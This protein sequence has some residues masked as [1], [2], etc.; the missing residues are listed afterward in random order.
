MTTDNLVGKIGTYYRFG[1]P[2]LGEIH[3]AFRDRKS[4]YG[5]LR[6]MPDRNGQPV[7]Q[8]R[9]EV[10]SDDGTPDGLEVRVLSYKYCSGR[11][12]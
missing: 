2:D 5:F 9:G 8:I 4:L 12:V 3:C 6:F 11:R 1:R 10:I 7:Y